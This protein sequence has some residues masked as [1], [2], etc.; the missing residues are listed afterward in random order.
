MKSPPEATTGQGVQEH[1]EFIK[2]T[3]DEGQRPRPKRDRADDDDDAG[4]KKEEKQVWSHETA[5]A[6]DEGWAG[7]GGQTTK[8]EDEERDAKSQ[9]TDGY[10]PTTTG[11]PGIIAG[12]SSSGEGVHLA[13][14]ARGG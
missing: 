14:P 11:K 9:K 4:V 5:P 12:S 2:E 6:W 1:Q 8:E 7:G 10:G 3:R 13:P